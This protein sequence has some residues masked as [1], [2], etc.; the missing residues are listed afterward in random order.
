M[1]PTAGGDGIFRRFLGH[2]APASAAE[3]GIYSGSARPQ[4]VWHQCGRGDV[5][6][7][8]VKPLTAAV[9]RQENTYRVPAE[10]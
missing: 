4:P 3:I 5:W 9:H 2:S 7:N 6:L 10:S 8:V 1:V